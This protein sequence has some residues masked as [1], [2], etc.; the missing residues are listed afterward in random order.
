MFTVPLTGFHKVL[1]LIPQVP[2]AVWT[3]FLT[4]LGSTLAALITGHYTVKGVKPTQKEAS[5]A[6]FDEWTKEH[7]ASA[8]DDK[9]E[10]Y[11]LSV[12]F[13]GAVSRLSFVTPNPKIKDKAL[14]LRDE[15]NRVADLLFN[16][17]GT[18]CES[19]RTFGRQVRA[20]IDTSITTRS[21]LEELVSGNILVMTKDSELP[22]GKPRKRSKWQESD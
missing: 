13:T 7:G 10:H 20:A 3:I 16:F 6:R 5:E 1:D 18:T 22:K 19:K 8:M 2:E 14:A 17:H 15:T 11:S 12:P 4:V 21:E 9:P